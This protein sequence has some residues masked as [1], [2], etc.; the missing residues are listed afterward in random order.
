MG[1]TK[2]DEERLGDP[3]SKESWDEKNGNFEDDDSDDDDD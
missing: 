2:D 1:W 3:C